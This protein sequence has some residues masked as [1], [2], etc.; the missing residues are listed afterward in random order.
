M[1]KENLKIQAL[2]ESISNLTSNYEEKIADLRVEVT[3]LTQELNNVRTQLEQS[4]AKIE[5]L[6]EV[7]AGVKENSEVVQ[8]EVVN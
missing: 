1:N 6:R 3:I 4:L 5:E 7:D 8:G 2:K